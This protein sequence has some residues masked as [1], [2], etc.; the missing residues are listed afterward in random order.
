MN[1]DV[2]PGFDSLYMF[3]MSRISS[4]PMLIHERYEIRLSQQV[5]R[6]SLCL[7]QVNG[8]GLELGDGFVVQDLLVEPL[9]VDV[10]LE[11]VAVGHRQA[12][13]DKLQIQDRENILRAKIIG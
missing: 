7:H 8:G 6:L 13:A 3:R 2:A 10:D 5:G 12:M 1:S 9:L 11:V 4:N